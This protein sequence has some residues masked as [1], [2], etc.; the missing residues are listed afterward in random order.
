MRIGHIGLSTHIGVA[1]E[2][3]VVLVEALSTHGV[4]QH[5]LVRNPFLAKRLS[6]CAGVSVGPIVRSSVTAYL[7]IP[8]VD[9]IHAHD[10][11]AVSAAMLL[12][13]TRFVPYIMT[14][15]QFSMPDNSP[16]RRLQYRRSA[17]I[18]CPSGDIA[19]AMLDYASD[20]PVDT[21]GDARNTDDEID[22][23]NGRISA[24]KLAAEYMRVYR[25]T[26]DSRSV[27]ALLL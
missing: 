22:A 25:R 6:V 20:R 8:A 15:R 13:M 5:V 3:L 21:I 17:G 10:K 9:L 12:N 26:I 7:L 18:V 2:Q 24:A 14:H 16:V 19:N 11:K 1:E 4:E 27:P 23:K